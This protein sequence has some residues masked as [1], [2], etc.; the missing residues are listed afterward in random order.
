MKFSQFSAFGH[1]YLVLGDGLDVH[2]VE[3]SM[4]RGIDCGH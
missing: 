2:C 4:F 1:D 3:E